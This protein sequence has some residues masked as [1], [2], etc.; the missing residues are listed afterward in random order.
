MS[1]A[2]LPTARFTTA[3]RWMVLVVWSGGL[4][5]GYA[6]SQASATLPFTRAGLGMTEGQMSL[7]L[8]LARL[9]AFAALPLARI[10]DRSGRRRPLIWAL[11][12][13]VVGGAGAGLA[14]DG[15]HYGLAQALMRTGTAAVT[16]LSVVLLSEQVTP[17]IRAYSV[18]FYA[19]AV[20]LGSGL[21]L[22]ALPLADGDPEGWRIP[23]F[24]T[25]SGLLII[26]LIARRLPES[27]LIRSQPQGR[28]SFSSLATGPWRRRFW[29]VAAIGLLI[30]A[31]GTFGLAFTIERMI[32]DLDFSTGMAVT[33]SLVG[34]TVGGV[35]FFLGGHLADSWGRRKTTIMA[36]MASLTGGLTL[37][38][39]EALPL[40]AAAVLVSSFGTFALAPAFGAHRAE[41]FP[42]PLRAMANTAAAN[43]ALA[44]SALGLLLGSFTIDR[45]GVA[46]TV[47]ILG[48]GVVVAAALTWRLPETLGHDLRVIDTDPR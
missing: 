20:S 42:T 37:Y 23:H 9:A 41:L 32:A 39:A 11:L 43:F 26:P 3:D 40:V 27:R 21:A 13:V 5:Q 45:I 44:G 35:G 33:V 8:G 4:I 29:L 47:R 6:Q 24:L 22:M 19:A 7:I 31:F 18:A 10:A 2:F 36:M 25:V 48:V 30:S 12:I 1:A 17:A 34:G 46:T 38:S 15:W 16:G 14:V 28:S